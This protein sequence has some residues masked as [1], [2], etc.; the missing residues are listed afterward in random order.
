MPDCTQC[1]TYG[2]GKRTTRDW[3]LTFG[4]ELCPACIIR[5]DDPDAEIE[6]QMSP[7]GMWS[8][9]KVD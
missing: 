8:A 7:W 1:G 3:D 5:K 2:H 6:A 9:R 4:A